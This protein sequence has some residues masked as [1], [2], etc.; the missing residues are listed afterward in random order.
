MLKNSSSMIDELLGWLASSES[1][2]TAMEEDPLPPEASLIEDMLREHQV[3][4][5]FYVLYNQFIRLYSILKN[6]LDLR[7]LLLLLVGSMSYQYNV[8]C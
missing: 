1:T 6:S 5:L 4:G 8:L 2:L 3:L 7:L